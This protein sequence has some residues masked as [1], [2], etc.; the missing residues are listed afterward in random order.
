MTLQE[1]AKLAGVSP[2]TVSLVLNNKPGVSQIKRDEILELLQKHNYSPHRTNTAPPI[3]KLLFLKHIK[4]GY[5]VEE[6][7]G[8]ITAILDA[9]ETECRKFNYSLRIIL[10]KNELETTIRGINFNSIAGI[11]VLGTELDETD[12]TLLNLISIP[13]IVIDNRIPNYSCNTITMNNTEMVYDAINHFHLSGFNSIAY[14]QSNSPTQ[15]FMDRADSFY[16]SCNQLGL[17]YQNEHIIKLMPTLMGA[18]SDMKDYLNNFPHLSLPPC[19]F[20]D[21]DTIAL[22]AMKALVEAGYSIPADIQIIGFD[23]IIYSAV[24]SPSLSTMQVDKKAIGEQAVRT[25]INAI[26]NKNIQNC[27]QFIGGNIILRDSTML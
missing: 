9:V 5:L 15:N 14:F 11:F 8:F 3:K 13:Y 6:N 10:S 23:N 24:N 16:N 17:S 25:L 27:K 2:A 7:A 12:Y 19:A 26:E 18:Y 22:G 20:A 4:N 1:I 21:N